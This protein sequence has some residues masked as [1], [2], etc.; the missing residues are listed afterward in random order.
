LLANQE[1]TVLV[2]GKSTRNCSFGGEYAFITNKYS[3]DLLHIYELIIMQ[4]FI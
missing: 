4:V 3:L 2:A 1:E